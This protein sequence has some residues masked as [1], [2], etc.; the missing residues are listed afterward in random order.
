[1]FEYLY[2]FVMLY[3]LIMAVVNIKNKYL[4][5]FL[6]CFPM[7]L[8]IIFRYGIGADYFSYQHLYE[9]LDVSSLGK[10]VDSNTSIEPGFK[11]LMYIFKLA[12]AP[13]HL[14][15]V[16]I[17]L[18]IFGLFVTWIVKSSPHYGISFLIFYGVFFF[19]WNLSA[20]RQALAIGLALHL[21]FRKERFSRLAEVLIVLGL[22]MVHRSAAILLI[23]IFSDKLRLNQKKILILFVVA[24]LFTIIPLYRIMQFIPETIPFVGRLFIYLGEGIN[25]FWNM[26]GL[27]RIAMLIPL[28]VLYP[29]YSIKGDY[30]KHIIESAILGFI[31]Y[32]FLRFSELAAARALVYSS[33]LIIV[34]YA[35]IASVYKDSVK[36]SFLVTSG[37]MAFVSLF[38]VKEMNALV[39]QTGLMPERRFG[40]PVTTIFNSNS[41]DFNNRFAFLVNQRLKYL[42][43]FEQYNEESMEPR[44]S[45]IVELKEDIDVELISIRFDDGYYGIMD[46]TGRI[47]RKPTFSYSPNIYRNFIE[48][49]NLAQ[50]TTYYT[51]LNGVRF[52]YEE[53]RDVILDAITAEVDIE[54]QTKSVRAA[55]ISILDQETL[56][57][58]PFVEQLEII[59]IT[60]VKAPF[61]YHILRVDYFGY[62]RYLYL[63]Q[64]NHLIIS[65][66][67]NEKR[68][69][70]S[71]GILNISNGFNNVILNREG[72]VL[73]M[74]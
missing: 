32:F 40:V 28:L 6:L 41:G 2:Y 39:E 50:N 29:S 70:D 21:L 45:S 24:L 15:N 20:L 14:F 9:V 43:M 65:Q 49:R 12:G 4:Q 59:D 1:M 26:Q 71:R 3:Y 60:T 73:W 34:L 53:I 31:I 36:K 8:V 5:L 46:T 35:E 37:L 56:S 58:F 52:R 22:V 30:E 54:K 69:F 10:F 55:D 42:E 19:V 27:L 51:A 11:T 38:F 66:L 33:I 67:F 25:P 72:E 16:L 44:V 23:Y 17:C 63:D 18:V 47:V 61:E 68:Y 74:E 57:L 64:D 62:S 13:Y 48:R 7:V